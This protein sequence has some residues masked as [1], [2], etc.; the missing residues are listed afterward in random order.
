MKI[1]G[2]EYK[3]NSKII[4]NRKSTKSK[5]EKFSME[6]ESS[7]LKHTKKDL[8]DMLSSIKKKGSTIVT[9]KTIENVTEYKSLVKEYLKK[10]F[11]EMYVLDKCS[12]TFNSKYYLTVETIDEKLKELTDK[13][14]RN[15]NDNIS[16]LNTID[17]IQGLMLSVYK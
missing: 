10:V 14:I 5:V 7:F 1:N 13:V 11:D 15:E 6:M 9:S 3:E 12:D 17:E 2:L 4:H 8:Q 16:I